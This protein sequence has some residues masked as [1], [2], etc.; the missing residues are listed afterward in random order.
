MRIT[1]ACIGLRVYLCTGVNLS[2]TFFFF[3][4]FSFF[5]FYS[6]PIKVQI[7]LNSLQTNVKCHCIF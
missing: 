2:Q 7:F 4:L 1:V 3:F 6:V 5:F